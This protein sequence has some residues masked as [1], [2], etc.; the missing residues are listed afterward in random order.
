MSSPVNKNGRHSSNA[1]H[2]FGP[3][4]GRGQRQKNERE[5]GIVFEFLLYLG[6]VEYSEVVI[7]LPCNLYVARQTSHAV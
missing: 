7:S 5:E 6:L 4:L 3:H 2:L 1:K